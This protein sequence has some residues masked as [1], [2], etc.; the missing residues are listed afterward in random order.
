VKKKLPI[1]AIGCV[2]LLGICIMLFPVVSD[3]LAKKAQSAVISN[4]QR[5]VDNLSDNEIE[6]LKSEAIKYNESLSGAVLS[7]PFSSEQGD[8]TGSFRLLNSGEV[9][10]YIEI[11]KI[12]VYL[13]IYHGTSE[14]ILQK[15]VGHLKN[16]SLPIGGKNTHAVLSAHRG[17]PSATLFTNLDQL[18][19]NDVFYIHILDEVLEYKVNQIKVIDPEDTSALIIQNGK[20]FITLVTCT[21]YGINTQRLLVRGERTEYTA[22]KGQ[23]Q[24]AP[25]LV[26]EITV[27]SPVF[28]ILAAFPIV[29]LIWKKKGEGT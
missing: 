1:I 2:M 20:D 14:E 23:I 25:A 10:G 21:P 9:I 5:T 12:D 26:N 24:S 16:T 11:P 22:P 17:L 27:V 4:Y 8:D 3:M 28:L 15:G 18:T 19:D 6:K 29:I 13:P 7:D